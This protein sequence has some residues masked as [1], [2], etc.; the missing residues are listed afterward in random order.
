VAGSASRIGAVLV[1]AFCVAVYAATLQRAVPGGDAGELIVVAASRAVAHPP[2]YPLWTML[3][4]LTT[5]VPA[6]SLAWRVAWMSALPAAGAAAAIHWCVASWLQPFAGRSS[7]AAAAGVLA[8]GL[9]A[10]SPTV[11]LY[12]TGAEV[13]SLHAFFAALLFALALAWQRSRKPRI[14][15]L[16]ALTAGLGLT[17]HLTL[18]FYVVPMAAWVVWTG[19]RALSAPR[20]AG[21]A[22][23][24]LAP[25]AYLWIA[26]RTDNPSSWGE[27]A[28]LGGF[29]DHLL[30]RDYGT[31]QLLPAGHAASSS[32]GAKLAAYAAHFSA[33]T[34][35]AG[36]AL[37]LVALVL[38][39][40]RDSF[41]ALVAGC[42]LLYL[43]AFLGLANVDVGDALLAGVLARFWLQADVALSI[44]AGIGFGLLTTGLGARR[45]AI[46][47][48]TSIVLVALRLGASGSEHRGDGVVEDYGR[49]ILE[50]LPPRT[51]LLTKGDLITNTVRY[52]QVAGHVRPD[53]I[54][55]DQELMTK[56]W[57]VR[58][59][60]A[61]HPDV[62]FPGDR[63]DPRE[64]GAFSMGAFLEA[65][66]DRTSIAVYPDWKEGD[67]S[68]DQWR[69]WPDGLAMR[70]FPANAPVDPSRWARDS[71][72]ALSALEA[73]GWPS[74]DR[75]EAG[76]WE[77]VVLEDV[78]QARHR[79]AVLLLTEAIAKHD[80]PGLLTIARGELEAAERMH[81]DPPAA[82]FKN[83]G[84]VYSRL[85]PSQ[86]WLRSQE[87]KAWESYLAKAD[88]DDK[89]RAVIEAQ[90]KKLPTGPKGAPAGD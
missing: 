72:A 8:A 81:P 45:A 83:L 32:L 74:M 5:L 1:F 85:G 73:R 44:L 26:G 71:A 58:R 22:L 67:A 49:A 19:R 76:S 41:V 36:V 37:A 11:W 39:G 4:W 60:A 38:R 80:D 15:P 64:A 90:V 18:V 21:A 52:V 10:F 27:T 56:P 61:L 30:R 20:L 54:A 17:N 79:R 35:G 48:A 28:T 33:A 2:G 68:V 13:F 23:A 34:F 57:Y 55:L 86:P 14:A 70:V 47:W 50:P 7:L 89:D 46:A 63:Y 6:G 40:T 51:L 12:A 25:Y 16:F 53:V 42:V 65:N 66:R 9:F 62:R 24:G 3:A 87:R 78:W 77:R 29:V 59:M 43:V 31:F 84:I 69:A 88:A 75:Y 82:L